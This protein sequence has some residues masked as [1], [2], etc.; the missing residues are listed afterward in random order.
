LADAVHV[1][2]ISRHP[3]RSARLILIGLCSYLIRSDAMS[4]EETAE[5]NRG[6]ENEGP[7]NTAAGNPVARTNL[8]LPFKSEEEARSKYVCS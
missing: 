3:I 2:I 7:R 1:I 5:A 4:G 6:R 8:Q